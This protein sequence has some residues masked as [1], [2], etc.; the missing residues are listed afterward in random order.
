MSKKENVNLRERSDEE[1]VENYSSL[2][3]E[4]RRQKII[5]ASRRIKADSI[6][7]VWNAIEKTISKTFRIKR[8]LKKDM[9]FGIK[10]KGLYTKFLLEEHNK[11]KFEI[12]IFWIN[13]NDKYWLHYQ[14]V[15]TMFKKTFK[16]K[17]KEIIHRDQTFFGLAD[18]AG[19]LLL[20]F[21]FRKNTNMFIKSMKEII[22]PKNKEDD[23]PNP[24]F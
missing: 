12:S 21:S 18:T 23:T 15:P 2:I 14:I 8:E 1:R 20:K 6:E 24:N 5:Y 11:E 4:F 16:I 7:E 9:E 3:D 17:F 19:E 22:Q 13:A 10:I